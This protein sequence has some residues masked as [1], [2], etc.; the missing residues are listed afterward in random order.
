[1][2]GVCCMPFPDEEPEVIPPV[3]GLV[4]G[5]S[6]AMI[7]DLLPEANLLPEESCCPYVLFPDEPVYRLDDDELEVTPDLDGAAAR[8]PDTALRPLP[9]EYVELLGLSEV[10]APPL[11]VVEPLCPK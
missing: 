7:P 9:E 8:V 1:M 5:L 10:A 11:R 6:V 4:A 3:E 2:A